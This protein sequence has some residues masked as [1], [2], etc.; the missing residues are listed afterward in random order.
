MKYY[1]S[2]I[3]IRVGLC[4]DWYAPRFL[5]LLNP[6]IAARCAIFF[7]WKDKC[8]SQ[9]QTLHPTPLEKFIR[10]ELDCWKD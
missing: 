5:V 1:F 2:M 4:T 3:Y 6:Y 8:I 7:N 10:Y 9:C